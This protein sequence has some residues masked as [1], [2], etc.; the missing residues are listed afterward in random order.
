MASRVVCREETRNAHLLTCF[1]GM[2]ATKD[3]FLSV[4]LLQ[5]NV[6]EKY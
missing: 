4:S 3:I 6:G 5:T 1:S 2:P